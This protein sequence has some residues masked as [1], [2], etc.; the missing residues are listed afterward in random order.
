MK[1]A[2]MLLCFTPALFAE[3]LTLNKQILGCRQ[4]IISRSN[5]SFNK[6]FSPIGAEDKA[7]DLVDDP[8]NLIRNIFDMEKKQLKSAV[9]KTLPWSDSYWPIYRGGIAQRYADKEFDMIDWKDAKSYVYQNPA[10]RLVA[11]GNWDKLSPA[12]KYDLLLGLTDLPLTLS[13]WE[14]G[15]EYVDQFGKVETWMG[16]C[17]GWAAASMMMKEPKKKVVIDSSLG[18]V[19]LNPSDIKGFATALWAKGEFETR[20]IG[21]RCNSKNPR[22]REN[23]CLDSNPGTWHMAVVNQIGVSGRSFVMDANSAYEVWNHPVYSYKYSYFNPKDKKDY[24]KLNEAILK[25]GEFKDSKEKYRAP[26]SIYIVG[27]RMTV[28][29]ALENEPSQAENQE[30]MSTEKTY[31]Y[32]LELNQ[33]YEIVGGE[34][35]S[36]DHP[37]F[38]W[39]PVKDAFPSTIGEAETTISFKRPSPEMKRLA[40]INAQMGVPW[41]PVVKKIVELSSK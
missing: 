18:K 33:D 29:Y 4:E 34:W 19:A 30:L 1:L 3:E 2:V 26:D 39:V 20:F 9:A 12:E 21:G 17:H 13:S 28:S 7:E 15:R 32:D 6:L 25:R 24:T 40:H 8:E 23:D 37:D 10:E 41:G 11:E 35:Q 22:N 27:V 16:L 36:S 5:H 31:E 14:E 38:L